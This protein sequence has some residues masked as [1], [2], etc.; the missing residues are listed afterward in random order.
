MMRKKNK[1]ALVLAFLIIILT[2][3]ATSSNETKKENDY[4]PDNFV[5]SYLTGDYAIRTNNHE[6]AAQ[7]FLNA[8]KQSPDNSILLSYSYNLMLKVGKIDESI[9]L[10]E[11]YIKLSDVDSNI[12]IL[13]ATQAIKNQDY[14]KA[15]EILNISTKHEPITVSSS[16]NRVI[17][18]FLKLWIMTGQNKN[19]EATD[20][21]NKK[22]EDSSAPSLFTHYQKALLNDFIGNAEEA[23]KSFTNVMS[24]DAILPY[25]FI[26]SAGNF[27]ERAGE[28]EQALLLYTKYRQQYPHSGYFQT[29]IDRINAG[30]E[31][32]EP[33]I[34]DA[35]YGFAEVL[36]EAARVLF[37]SGY[38]DEGISYLRLAMYLK[39]ENDET[40]VL[41]SGFYEDIEQYKSAIKIYKKVPEG[42]DFYL[43]GRISIAENYHNAGEKDKAISLLKQLTDNE[44]PSMIAL[45]TL[46]DLYRKDLKFKEA[47][48]AYSK[49]I[50]MIKNPSVQN[51]LI[52]FARGISFERSKQWGLAEKDLLKALELKPEQP[53]V[54]NY[55]GYSWIDRNENIDKAKGMIEKAVKARPNDPQIID[56]M[57]WALYKMND[58]EKASEY[59]EKAVEI[60][61]YDSTI[62]DHLGDTY[63]RLGRTNEAVFQWK[64]VLKYNTNKDLSEKD[65]RQKI[66]YGLPEGNGN[67]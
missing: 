56:S 51:W 48:D 30:N 47:A 18:P 6:E 34:K 22:I 53:E 19:S 7:I 65:I 42:S 67:S 31:K 23:N 43:T 5:K 66:R 4:F 63:W 27:Y 59:L 12:N 54:L 41:L 52:F 64:R 36:E 10:A 55:L 20:F 35:R 1:F 33:L 46:A 3:K 45:L 25:H 17:S 8:S 2:Q 21:I 32:P 39:P 24:K 44:N 28:K 57:G 49:A 62:N 15:E 37:N 29:N 16:I 14:D 60:T 58:F 50:A 11:K 13:R 38:S 61:P 9:E 26:N 40:R